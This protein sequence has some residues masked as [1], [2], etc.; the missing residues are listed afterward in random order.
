MIEWLVAAPAS[1]GG[2]T[3]L[4]CALLQALKRRGLSPCA[5]KCGPDYIDSM[6]HRAVLGVASCNL[7]LFLSDETAVRRLYARGCAGHGAAIV[8]GVMG[9]YDGLGGV[10]DRASAWHMADTLG[11]PVLLCLRPKGSSLTLAAQVKGL[12]AFRR[13]SHIAAL[14]LTDCSAMLYQTL[15]P[16]LER[17]TGLPVLGYLP[18]METAVVESRHLGLRTAGE[19]KDLAA[20]LCAVAAV[21]EETLDWPRFFALGRGPARPLP[22]RETEPGALRVPIAVAQDEAFCFTYAESLDMLRR[23]GAQLLPF[24]PLDDRALPE[25]A[26]ALYLP[27]GYPELYA[28]QLSENIALRAAIRDAG[29]EGLPTAAECGGFLYLGQTLEGTDSKVYPMTG[30]LPGSGHNAGRLVRFGY[31]AMTAKSDSMLFHAGETLPVH[32]FHHW[33]SSEN[34]ADFSVHKTEKRQWK[35]GFANAHLYAGFP[36]LYWAGTALPRRFVQAAQ[37]FLKHKG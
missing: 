24:R 29:Q 27:G 22:D 3:V 36:H 15:S 28:R 1:G 6:F 9:L 13:D 20:R 35:C 7:D 25:G 34:G 32:E 11:L 4:A 12:Q 23:C 18:H 37:H 2:K 14:F 16:M 26:C 31:A 10:T 30:V 8:E 17:E 33:D 19:I 5:F 21:L